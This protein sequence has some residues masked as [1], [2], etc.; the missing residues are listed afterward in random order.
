MVMSSRPT[1]VKF[2]MQ[3]DLIIKMKL[4]DLM[5]IQDFEQISITMHQ[6]ILQQPILQRSTHSAT[7]SRWL[8]NSR[9][10]WFP[11]LNPFWNAFFTPDNL[12]NGLISRNSETKF[13]SKNTFSHEYNMARV[14]DWFGVILQ[15]LLSQD[16][17]IV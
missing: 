13:S 12:Q 14:N 5:S 4:A 10:G 15:N 3:W 17:A 7:L 6:P 16:P 11:E 8:K 9:M 1:R 2:F